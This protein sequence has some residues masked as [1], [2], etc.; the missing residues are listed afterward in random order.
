VLSDVIVLLPSIVVVR[1]VQETLLPLLVELMKSE[2]ESVV[3]SAA[4]CVASLYA[5]LEEEGIARGLK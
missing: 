2:H 5:K 3:C 1:T 4:H